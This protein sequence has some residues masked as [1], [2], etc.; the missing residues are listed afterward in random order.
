MK[1]YLRRRSTY[2]KAIIALCIFYI[3]A[4]FYVWAKDAHDIHIC[5]T[6]LKFNETSSSFQVSIKIFIDDLELTLSK[7][8]TSGLFLGTPKES[9]DADEF[10]EGY[11]NKHFKI[12][13]DGEPLE[14]V[15]LGKEVSEDLQAI[16]CYVEFTA[17]PMHGKKCTL[18]NDILFSQFE[19]QRNIMD[20]RMRKNHKDYIILQP[21]HSTWTYT[22]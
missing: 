16:W 4:P 22:Y 2:V 17:Q 10:I 9:G 15:F 20:I 6:E 13:I 5:L 19:D 11:L 12:D 18:S 1:V 7:E 8:G 14:M 3:C 21:G